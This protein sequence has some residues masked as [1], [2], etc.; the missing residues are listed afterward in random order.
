MI[1]RLPVRGAQGNT[2][3]YH[4]RAPAAAANGAES[5]GNPSRSEQ[6]RA[7]A[8]QYCL[9]LNSAASAI[10]CAWMAISDR[11]V[12]ACERINPGKGDGCAW[13]ENGG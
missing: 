6:R 8:F 13:G 3:M 9:G 4:L 7:D 2:C 10:W 5:S 12:T 1:R 11:T